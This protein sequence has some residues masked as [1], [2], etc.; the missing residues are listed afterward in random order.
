[1]LTSLRTLTAL[2][3]FSTLSLSA[4]AAGSDW[5]Q[6]RGPDRTDVS[7][8]TGLLWNSWPAAGPK[9]VWLFENAGQGYS[10]PAI[11]NGKYF[12]LGTRDGSEIL[13]VLDANT[14]KELWTAKLARS[15]TTAGATAR[16][17]R[18]PSMATASTP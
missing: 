18:P 3:A 13:L 8:E 15:S 7:I 2:L 11:A 17:A 9:R 6:W 10:G 4:S 14:G 16:A 5:P 1:M 12:T